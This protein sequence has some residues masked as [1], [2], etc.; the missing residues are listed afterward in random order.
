MTDNTTSRKPPV[1]FRDATLEPLLEERAPEPGGLGLIAKR[2]LTRYY[3][4]LRRE[5]KTVAQ[6]LTPSEALALCDISN[7]TLW[8]E[9]SAALLWAEVADADQAQLDQWGVNRDTLVAK[10]RA[11]TPAQSLAVVDA[12]ERW[13]LLPE[14]VA[15]DQD[16]GLAAVGLQ[17]PPRRP[18][19]TGE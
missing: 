18:L 17:A 7:G 11:L 1:S 2:D 6:L 4:A 16:R 5:L 13:W 3:D 14:D 12:L 8:D 19:P 15:S 9:V 10:L